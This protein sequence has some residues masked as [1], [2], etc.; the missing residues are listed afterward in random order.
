MTDHSAAVMNA[1][2]WLSTTPDSQRPRPIIPHI[3]KTFGLSHREA[4]EA[5]REANLI[6]ARAA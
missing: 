4:V 6:K 3:I 2:H 1:A 5:I